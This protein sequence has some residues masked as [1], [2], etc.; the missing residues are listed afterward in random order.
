MAAALSEERGTLEDVIEPYLI[1]QGFLVRTARGRM[2]TA[3]AYRHWG[4]KPLKPV[5]DLFVA[6]DEAG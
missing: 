3:N 1:Q 4:L 2:A 5:A 6:N